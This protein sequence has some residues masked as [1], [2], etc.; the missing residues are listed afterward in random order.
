[1]T[2]GSQ[3]SINEF[4]GESYEHDFKLRNTANHGFPF[5][6]PGCVPGENNNFWAT[7]DG[8]WYRTTYP[9]AAKPYFDTDYSDSCELQDFTIGVYFPLKLTAGKKYETIV[10]TRAGE[11]NSS[12]YQLAG[13]RLKRD[14]S[15]SPFCVGV[16]PRPEKAQVFVG[17]TKGSAPECRRWRK[18]RSSRPC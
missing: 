5:I 18:G 7:R 13:E 9:K 6:R 4:I 11:N 16:R 3:A 12:E 14:C 15:S 8:K 17:F 1:M 2:W 10:R